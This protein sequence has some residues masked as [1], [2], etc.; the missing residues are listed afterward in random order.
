MVYTAVSKS[1]AVDPAALGPSHRASFVNTS[2]GFCAP[3]W[4]ALDYPLWSEKPRADPER[5]P[6][7][8]KGMRDNAFLCE[9]RSK[10]PA[11]FSG[12]TTTISTD[13]S[14]PISSDSSRAKNR[15]VSVLRPDFDCGAIG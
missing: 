13:T 12:Q 3:M 14:T 1:W 7:K 15:L 10:T 4:Q 5:P 8:K 6:G 9:R 11:E 2:S